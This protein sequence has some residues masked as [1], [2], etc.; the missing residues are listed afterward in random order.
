VHRNPLWLED[1][2][3][4]LRKLAADGLS[5]SQIAKEIGAVS[6]SAVL[7]RANRIGIKLGG[8]RYVRR[9][10]QER[11]ERKNEMRRKRRAAAADRPISLRADTRS[12]AKRLADAY[13]AADAVAEA[14]PQAQTAEQKA[15]N[16]S[17]LQLSDRTCK[18]PIGD[19]QS[20]D[21]TFCGAA[22]NSI[23][24]YCHRH[25][26]LCY[27]RPYEVERHAPTLSVESPRVANGGAS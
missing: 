26:R 24:P 20:P 25:H 11:T 6:R 10:P 3:A 14:T 12:P 7:G 15:L 27:R 17:L 4:R 1:R 19:P 18:Y 23:G 8:D 5:A 13:A 9:T 21:F 16:V 2:D 22:P